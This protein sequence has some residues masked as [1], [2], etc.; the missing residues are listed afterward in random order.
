MG[1]VGEKR[2]RNAEAA[3]FTQRCREEV[4]ESEDRRG[5]EEE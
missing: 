5:L 4:F 1:F 3:K 2:G